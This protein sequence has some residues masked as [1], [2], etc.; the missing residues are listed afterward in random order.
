MLRSFLDEGWEGNDL[1]PSSQKEDLCEVSVSYVLVSE[2]DE[3]AL[4]LPQESGQVLGWVTPL[5]PHGV[6]ELLGYF[7]LPKI[8][9]CS[10][11]EGS[12]KEDPFSASNMQVD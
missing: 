2:E 1:L 10:R 6:F 5:V 4:Q 11:V 3:G 9:E 12:R 7:W 8:W